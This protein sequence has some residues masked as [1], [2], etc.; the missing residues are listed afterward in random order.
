METSNNIDPQLDLARPD[1]AVVVRLR[2]KAV[3]GYRHRCRV[4]CNNLAMLLA[5]WQFRVG[6][7]DFPAVR[8]AR[9]LG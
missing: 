3:P 8:W 5:A 2:G 7:A 9:E 6:C 1:L 4:A